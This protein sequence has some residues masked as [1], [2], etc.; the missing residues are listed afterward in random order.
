MDCGG[1]VCPA[2]AVSSLAVNTLALSQSKA[3]RKWSAR[4][5]VRVVDEQNRAVGKAKVTGT[6]KRKY[7]IC[8]TPLKEIRD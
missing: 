5:I 4:V 2:C 1:S 7:V 6:F 8:K 3:N